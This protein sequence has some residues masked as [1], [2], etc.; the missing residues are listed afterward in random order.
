MPDEAVAESSSAETEV[1][2]SA[3]EQVETSAQT[4]EGAEA[5]AA[6][7]TTESKDESV[8]AS[9]AAK[10]SEPSK[11]ERRIKQLDAKVKELSKQLSQYK[12]AEKSQATEPV[13]PQLENFQ[14]VE[15]FQAAS[16]EFK[17]K[18]KDFVLEQAAQEA[19]AKTQREQQAAV[20]KVA[21]EAWEKSEKATIKRNAEYNRETALETVQPSPTM[22][23]FFVDSEVGPDLLWHLSE[24][25]D[26]ADKIRDLP[27]YRAV[28]E[29]IA[30]EAK[31]TAQI[32]GIRKPNAAGKPGGYV[33]GTGSGPGKPKTAEEIF[34]GS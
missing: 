20:E 7:S 11:A 15:E 17:G 19:Q 27:P 34:Y 3:T 29:L 26:V 14:T 8:S 18:Y 16:K 10:R 30:L 24:N 13:E 23:G 28:R 31:L 5:V 12:P 6:E 9:E 22:D 21:Q 32:K 25:P 2:E 33:S 1:T 4:E